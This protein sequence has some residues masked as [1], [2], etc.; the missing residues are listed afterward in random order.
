[1]ENVSFT[2]VEE[3]KCIRCVFSLSLEEFNAFELV[4]SADC[5][6]VNRPVEVVGPLSEFDIQ[7]VSSS[8]PPTFV[9]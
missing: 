2:S 9:Q 3:D 6:P 1:M 4:L 7:T 8:R 5:Y